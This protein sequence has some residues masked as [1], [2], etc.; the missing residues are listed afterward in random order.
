MKGFFREGAPLITS[1]N[2]GSEYFIQTNEPQQIQLSCQTKNDV[3]EVFWYVN[4]K[5]V[6]RSSPHEAVFISPPVGRVK[7]SCSDDKGRNSDIHIV[8][9]KF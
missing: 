7:I 1:P 2:D 3:Q 6:K 5:L 8:V 9:K 4:D